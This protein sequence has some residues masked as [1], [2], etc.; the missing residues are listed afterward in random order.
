MNKFL[1]A[2]IFLTA[3][4]SSCR[5]NPNL[6]N[7]GTDYV[8]GEWQEEEV[9][10]ADQLLQFTRHTIKFD[11]DSF[12]ITFKTTSKVNI[13][14][15]TCYSSGQWTEYAKGGYLIKKDTLYL[16]GTFAKSN[17]KQKIS[18]CFRNGQYLESFIIKNHTGDSLNLESMQQHFPL[19]LTLKERT[20]C[21]PKPV[22]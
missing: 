10:Y 5:F 22:N 13:N 8:Q 4:F 3:L 9:E 14:P 20:S 7:K 15:D 6:Q 17:F 18:G 11:C 12:F 2:L 19:K 16:S 21:K 1:T